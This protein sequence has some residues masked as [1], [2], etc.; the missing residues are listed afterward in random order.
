MSQSGKE[1]LMDLSR[2]VV[3]RL[4]GQQMA[5]GGRESGEGSSQLLMF[6]HRF[7]SRSWLSLPLSHFV[8]DLSRPGRALLETRHLCT[9]RLIPFQ[10]IKQATRGS[11]V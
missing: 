5:M 7:K 9:P 11:T 4:P 1:P 2:R 3:R 8:K 10:Q 6:A